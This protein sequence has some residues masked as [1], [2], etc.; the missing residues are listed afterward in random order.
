MKSQTIISKPYKTTIEASVGLIRQAIA[1]NKQNAQAI[2][3]ILANLIFD[4]GMWKAIAQII[5]VEDVDDIHSEAFSFCHL[6]AKYSDLYEDLLPEVDNLNLIGDNAVWQDIK[7][8]LLDIYFYQA[9]NF[10]RLERIAETGGGYFKASDRK[11]DGDPQATLDFNPTNKPVTFREASNRAFDASFYVQVAE[12][13]T[14]ALQDYDR[15]VLKKQ[16]EKL[17]LR[18]LDIIPSR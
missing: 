8:Y 7:T 16:R 10:G 9:V 18:T 14:K 4:K 12:T 3:I 15:T 6:P 2:H 5:R 13:E 17:I 1:E 11:K